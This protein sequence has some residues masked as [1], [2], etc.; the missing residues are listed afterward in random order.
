MGNRVKKLNDI[1]INKNGEYILYW[2]QQS[3]RVE[4][5]HALSYGI[6]EAERLNLPLVVFFVLT[7]YP[8]ANERH[9]FFMLEGLKEVKAELNKR[10]IK[11]VLQIGNP[12]ELVYEVS[13]KSAITIFDKGYMKI[14]KI[15]REKLREFIE[16]PLVEVE[17]DLIVP[18][19]IA[20][21]KEEYAAYTIRKKIH[22]ELDEYMVEMKLPEIGK[23]SLT[24]D[25]F[26]E[27][28]EDVEALVD[29]LN[30]GKE[31][32]R[33]KYFRGGYNEARKRLDNFIEIKLDKYTEL[34]NNPSFDYTSTLSPYLHFGQISPLEIAI[35][36]RKSGENSESV[37]TFL[38]EL[39][40]RRELAFNFCYY[41]QDY[42]NYK[43]LKANWIYET[44]EKH[45]EDER[46][47]V[48]S[49]EELE[50]AETHDEIWNACQREL[51]HTGDMHGYM[52]M[53]WGKKILEWSL[54]PKEA[55][56]SAIYLNNKYA[57]DGRDANSFAGIAWCFGKHDRPWFEREIFGK[58]RYMNDKGLKRKFKV[59]NYIQKVN[60]MVEDLR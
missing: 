29:K 59:E 47:Y 51:L 22:R 13:K 5:N 41:N 38:E 44:L 49:L 36:I 18:I 50:K 20:S 55:F 52:R 28:V 58:V 30:L 19:E 14:Q 17:S 31:V 15:W 40:V 7:S 32:A 35:E 12:E 6:M 57:L 43:G 39:I 54:T 10:K 24:L 46:E 9:Y 26:S 25:I 37:G 11:F 42:D 60:K 56:E 23:S 3:Q 34:K 16:V 4:Y 8:E 27:E 53:Y 45:K 48:Y 21:Q 33:T 1:E 2:M